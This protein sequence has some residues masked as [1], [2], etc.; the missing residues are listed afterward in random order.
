VAYDFCYHPSVFIRQTYSVNAIGRTPGLGGLGPACEPPEVPVAKA[1][2]RSDKKP[3]S[4]TIGYEAELWQ[5]ADAL[6]G[7]MDAAEYKH[8]VLGLIF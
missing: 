5:V 8:V 3:A 1:A 2:T 7:R 4:A 6:C